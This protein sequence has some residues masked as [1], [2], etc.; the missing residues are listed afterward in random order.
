MERW[1][2]QEDEQL[3]EEAEA[4][5]SRSGSKLTMIEEGDE[6]CEETYPASGEQ[7]GAPCLQEEPSEGE[8]RSAH[9]GPALCAPAPRTRRRSQ[10]PARR[11]VAP[12]P[13]LA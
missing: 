13:N 9:G 1:A 11:E 12:R 4:V 5:R 3:G 2:Y 7:G 8:P 6:T 10:P